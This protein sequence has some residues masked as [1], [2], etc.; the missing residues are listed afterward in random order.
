MRR[1]RRDRGGASSR[2]RCAVSDGRA[3]ELRARLVETA[4]LHEEVAAHR[5]QE[6]VV[7]RAGSEASASTKRQPFRRAEGHGDGGPRGSARRR[8]MARSGRARRRA[9]R[10]ASSRSPPQ[11]A[12]ARG[13]RQSRPGARRG[14]AS[15]ELL[16]ARQRR[17]PRRHEQVIQRER[18][19][20][21][22]GSALPKGR[23]SCRKTCLFLFVRL[24]PTSPNVQVTEVARKDLTI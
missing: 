7:L 9:P 6:M 24:S 21:G 10:C 19:D 22:A 12:S 13:R 1:G 20:R 16:G 15:P 18:P 17:E 11:C 4:E 23:T 8:G 5:G 2:A 3:L 14:R